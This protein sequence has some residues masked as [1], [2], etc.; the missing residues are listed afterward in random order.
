VAGKEGIQVLF[1][2]NDQRIVRNTVTT[3]RMRIEEDGM[4]MNSNLK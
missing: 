4:E 3:D 2:E 1:H